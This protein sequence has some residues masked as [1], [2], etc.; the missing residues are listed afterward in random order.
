M[1]QRR[2][3]RIH[4]YVVNYTKRALLLRN[5]NDIG[6]SALD[7]SLDLKIDRANASKDLN[8]LWKA[9]KLIKIDGRPVLYID[10]NELSI[11]Y[12]HKFFPLYVPV[13]EKII[14]YLEKNNVVNEQLDDKKAVDALDS[15]IGSNASLK[16]VVE[17]AKAAVAYPPYGLP[18][19]LIGNPGSGKLRFADAIYQ[20]AIQKK[21]K[22]PSSEFIIVNCQS[23]LN[24]YDMLLH[25]LYGSK[26]KNGKMEKGLVDQV[27]SGILYFDGINNLDAK[28]LSIVVDLINNQQM[29]I[30]NS[31]NRPI[32]NSTII[33]SIAS[34]SDYSLQRSIDSVFT[35]KLNF[36]DI[37]KRSIFEKIEL[38]F[39]FFAREAKTINMNIHID[40]N[41]LLLFADATYTENEVEMRTEIKLVCSNAYLSAKMARSSVI[42]VDYPHLTNR[43]L[44]F[45]PNDLSYDSR[46][47]SVLSLIP[48]DYY[49][50]EADGNSSAFNSLYDKISTS[51]AK[52]FRLFLNEFKRNLDAMYQFDDYIVEILDTTKT[53]DNVLINQLSNEISNII[54]DTFFREL[55]RHQKYSNFL[56]NRKYLI[57]LL[58]QIS[59]MAKYENTPQ[60]IAESDDDLYIMTRSVL[61]EIENYCH[62]YFTQTEI[63]YACRYL[64]IVSQEL[65][66]RKVSILVITRGEH[67]ASEMVKE[68]KTLVHNIK[69]EAIDYHYI[70]LNDVLE[71]AINYTNKIDQGAGVL[72]MVDMEPL[73]SIDDHIHN[74]TGT[75]CRVISDISLTKLTTAIE[76]CEKGFRLNDIK[77]N[78]SSVVKKEHQEIE[79]DYIYKMV[80]KVLESTLSFINPKKAAD[81]SLICLKQLL[82]DFTLEYNEEIATK[83]VSHTI[84]MFERIIRNDPL[85]Y[86][87]LSSFVTKNQ[88][89][90]DI[91]A[92][93]MKYAE[94]SFGIT[95]PTSE[96]AYICEIFTDRNIVL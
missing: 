23:Y 26:D 31:A 80:H 32:C 34:N 69:I 85:K 53:A 12:P 79:D 78:D 94:E 75:E 10:H 4:D 27:N 47:L 25:L 9:G 1:E 40:K 61:N 76:Y 81:V 55:S 59:Y 64:Q 82:N 17:K 38:I 48:E 68:A 70:Q 2:I 83:F 88:K 90:M 21:F 73:N 30:S 50:F 8:S 11:F 45:K 77:I 91:I 93:D 35:V 51:S 72:I 36:P 19:L 89:M 28:S 95:M 42:H 74:T 86:H 13:G 39:Y 58:L 43:L 92:K 20:F 29:E 37:D 87:R 22:K 24:N 63:N 60:T 7:I 67:I 56:E 6:T 41:I 65:T 66:T 18:I 5:Q 54:Y 14:N 52:N 3:D 62:H 96:L 84:N 33:A 57:G 71:L 49:I 46:A 44:S 16:E 15:Y